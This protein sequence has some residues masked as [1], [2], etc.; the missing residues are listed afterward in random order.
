MTTVAYL[1]ATIVVAT[2]FF[3]GI[4]HLVRAYFSYLL[5]LT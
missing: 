1:A 5:D 2:H 4:R 3:F